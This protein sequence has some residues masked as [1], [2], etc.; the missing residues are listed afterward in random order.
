MLTKSSLPLVA[1]IGSLVIV[2]VCD[3][4]DDRKSFSD[5]AVRYGEQLLIVS[6]PDLSAFGGQS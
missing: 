3:G 6:T 5:A 2:Y 1:G 4:S